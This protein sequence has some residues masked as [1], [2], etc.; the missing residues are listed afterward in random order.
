MYSVSSVPFTYVVAF[1][2]VD[3]VISESCLLNGD[4]D[5]PVLNAA[6]C[7]IWGA[8]FVKRKSE[9]YSR[10]MEAA[11]QVRGASHLMVF[12]A[13]NDVTWDGTDS[14][15]LDWAI[16]EP[17]ACF[18]ISTFPL[19]RFKIVARKVFSSLPIQRCQKQTALLSSRILFRLHA[20][21][22]RRSSGKLASI[23]GSRRSPLLMS[24]LAKIE[25]FTRVS[26]CSLLLGSL[27]ISVHD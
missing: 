15:T 2:Q 18:I 10:F 4:G 26:D 24:S 8:A 1:S 25:G 21:L 9:R 22:T 11:W 16:Q 3:A 7:S 23:W 5:Q 19:P 13:G 12:V 27:P 14:D 6:C 17:T 20:L